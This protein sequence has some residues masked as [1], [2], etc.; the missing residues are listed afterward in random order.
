MKSILYWTLIKTTW[1]RRHTPFG[2]TSEGPRGRINGRYEDDH[3]SH[4]TARD[5]VGK[6]DT[7][8]Q[9]KKKAAHVA[10]IRATHAKDRELPQLEINRSHELEDKE[11]A[12]W[13]AIP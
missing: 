11:I 13:L 3:P 9:A 5:I 10:I 2:V 4:T 6:F 8:E 7:L 1:N 12:A